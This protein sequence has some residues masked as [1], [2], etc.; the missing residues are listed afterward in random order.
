MSDKKPKGKDK[1]S[2]EQV[3]EFTQENT[4]ILEY[5]D[6]VKHEYDCEAEIKTSFEN[7]AGVLLTL[8]GAVCIFLFD[9]VKL[10]FR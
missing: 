8:L 7:R 10:C 2:V 3:C 6:A 1:P 9:K 4:A 5:L